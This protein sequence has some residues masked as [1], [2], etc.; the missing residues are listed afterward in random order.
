MSMLMNQAMPPEIAV[1]DDT[2]F[3]GD[4][5]EFEITVVKQ[6]A[7][8]DLTD[9]HWWC[10]G[11][12][13]RSSTSDTDALFQVTETP[14]AQGVITSPAAGVLHVKLEP[15]A[16]AGLPA[17]DSPVQIDV[18]WEEATGEVWTVAS[19]TLTFLADVTRSG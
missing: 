15:A 18:Q 12:W 9:G 5:V 13:W 14:T 11:K 8:A 3:R 17:R 19:G 1:I 10:T 7:P 4:T 2:A 6:N 16:S